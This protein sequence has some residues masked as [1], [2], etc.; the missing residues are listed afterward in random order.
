MQELPGLYLAH[1]ALHA[2]PWLWERVH[3]VHHR[4]RAPTAAAVLYIHPLDT[5]IQ[6]GVPML[7]AC[8]MLQPHLAPWYLWVTLHLCETT[9][10]HAGLFDGKGGGGGG[11][12]GSDDRALARV[13]AAASLLLFR[14]L[15]GRADT[16][17][18]DRHHAKSNHA[19]RAL[20]LA[21]TWWVLD[22]LGGTLA[23]G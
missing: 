21:E 13:E 8:A 20:N 23:R 1:R 17:H 4:I 10:N 22:A 18:H 2:H 14:W 6:Q 11:K 16:R 9:L 15:P 7:T 19:G 5:A 3:C 12:G